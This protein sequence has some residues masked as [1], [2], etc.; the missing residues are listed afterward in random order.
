MNLDRIIK[1]LERKTWTRIV[2]F[3]SSNTER[4]IHGTHWFDWFEL[5]VKHTHGRIAHFI[6]AGLSGDT[7]RGLLERLETQAAIYSPDVV[8][9]TIGGNDSGVDTGID[10]SEFRSNLTA[11]EERIRSSGATL[12]FQ[13]YYS[14]DLSQD[15]PERA[16]RFLQYMQIVRE[17]APTTGSG[18]IDHLT[19][20]EP[21]RLCHPQ[22]YRTLMRDANHVNTLGNMVLGLDLNRAFGLHL[23][24]ATLAHCGEGLRI[25]KILDELSTQTTS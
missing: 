21:L 15:Q 23:D 11:L 3:G 10:E 18:L 13:T 1:R 5:G 14:Q 22:E 7:S 6:N 12:V 9:V 24:A 25:Q 2:A 19:R 16:T 4:F 8:V 17:V 20:W